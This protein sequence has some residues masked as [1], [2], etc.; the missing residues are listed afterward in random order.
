[1]LALATDLPEVELAPGDAVVREGGRSGSIWVLVSGALEV[2]KGDVVVNTI[3]HPGALVG[4]ISVLLGTDHAATVLATEPS[5]LR[6]AHTRLQSM[7]LEPAE[8]RLA[9]TLV[10][11]AERVGLPREGETEIAVTRQE[12]ADMAGTTV[13]SAIRAT[14]AWKRAGIVATV[15]SH[16]RVV[17]HLA[18]RAIAA[19][20]GART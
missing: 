6:H 20:R 18:L 5:R 14:G 17:D 12:L 16:I 1:M 19:G 4:E 3:T 15:R 7:A 9:R 2:R 11:L 8:Q 10:M 13:E